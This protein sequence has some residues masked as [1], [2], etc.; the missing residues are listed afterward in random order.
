MW[1]NLKIRDMSVIQHNFLIKVMI[2]IFSLLKRSSTVKEITG[3]TIRLSNCT[4]C[5]MQRVCEWIHRGNKASKHKQTK[6]KAKQFRH[7]PVWRCWAGWKRPRNRW[8]WIARCRRTCRHC[9]RTFR[10][11]WSYPKWE[12]AAIGIGVKWVSMGNTIASLTWTKSANFFWLLSYTL[13]TFEGMASC[14]RFTD[15]AVLAGVGNSEICWKKSYL[16]T[17]K[18]IISYYIS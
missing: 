18:M 14:S 5:I 10:A 17:T 9:C 1:I 6:K 12:R 3:W 11:H 7:S 8:Q 4:G 15:S 2:T 16:V 13:N